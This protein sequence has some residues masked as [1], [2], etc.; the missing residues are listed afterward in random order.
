MPLAIFTFTFQRSKGRPISCVSLY[1]IYRADTF[2]HPHP[3]NKVNMDCRFKSKVQNGEESFLFPI[4]PQKE[5]CQRASKLFWWPIC[6]IFV[7]YLFIL[8]CTV[9]TFWIWMYSIFWIFWIGWKGC[10][11]SLQ[12]QKGYVRWSLYYELKDLGGTQCCNF[13]PSDQILLFLTTSIHIFID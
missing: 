10:R 7:N 1:P 13:V 4:L 2:R 6:D 5:S 3:V 11:W 8:G 9:D 12:Q